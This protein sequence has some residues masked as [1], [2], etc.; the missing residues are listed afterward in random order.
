MSTSGNIIQIKVYEPLPEI[1]VG[2]LL[3]F[4][5]SETWKKSTWRSG[6]YLVKKTSSARII[7]DRA[8]NGFFSAEN[9]WNSDLLGIVNDSRPNCSCSVFLLR[10]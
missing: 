8:V 9:L 5:F 7:L 1:K 10:N 6:I 4:Q 3:C 2:D